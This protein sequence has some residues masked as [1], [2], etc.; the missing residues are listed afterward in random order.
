MCVDHESCQVMRQLNPNGS[1]HQWTK[2]ASGDSRAHNSA[3]GFGSWFGSRDWGLVT[4]HPPEFLACLY[5]NLIILS[6]WCLGHQEQSD[7]RCTI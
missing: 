1:Q 7:L 5:Q 4:C 6:M 2:A 3:F